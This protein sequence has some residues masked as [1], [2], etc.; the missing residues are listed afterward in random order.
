MEHLLSGILLEIRTF[1]FDLYDFPNKKIG[2]PSAKLCR[3]I[4]LLNFVLESIVPKIVEC[5]LDIKEGRFHMFT[6][7]V[8]F[9]NCLRE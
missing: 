1:N 3:Q 6:T 2:E 8:T 4:K 7:T 9:H 5:F